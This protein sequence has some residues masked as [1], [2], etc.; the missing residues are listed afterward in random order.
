MERP[1]RDSLRL[2]P[3]YPSLKVPGKWARSSFPSGAPMKRDALLHSLSFTSFLHLSKSLVHVLLPGSTTG[4]QGKR[5]RSPEP[6]CTYPS[7]SP[8]KEPTFQ[9]PFTELPGRVM[10]FFLSQLSTNS[11]DY[12]KQT[13]NKS[14]FP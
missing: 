6:S 8:V 12:G 2:Q 13:P 10:L 11:Q 1:H 7:G 4:P 14:A 9:V 3:L 5:Y